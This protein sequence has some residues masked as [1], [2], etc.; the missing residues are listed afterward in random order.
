MQNEWDTGFFKGQ[1]TMAELIIS[2]EKFIIKVL[3]Q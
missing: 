1:G 3:T 2:F